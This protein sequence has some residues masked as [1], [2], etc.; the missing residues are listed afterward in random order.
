MEGHLLKDSYIIG[1][2]GN[3]L[4]PTYVLTLN[5]MQLQGTLICRKHEC[6]LFASLIG[7]I[8]TLIIIYNIRN[9]NVKMLSASV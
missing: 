4:S 9:Y 8:E 1:L 5:N 7:D 2:L 6:L 3:Q